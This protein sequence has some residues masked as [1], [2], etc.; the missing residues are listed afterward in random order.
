[1]SGQRDGMISVIRRPFLA[2]EDEGMK[3][4]ATLPLAIS[5][6][7]M[8]A[9]FLRVGELGLVV[10]SIA[11]PFVLLSRHPLAVRVIQMLLLA[12]GAEWIHTAYGLASGRAAAGMP[13][14]RML[15]ILGGVI[16]FTVSSIFP[17]ERLRRAGS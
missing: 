10:F 1:V 15:V 16:V 13:Y 9:H 12:A 3:W 7:L 14:A 5:A 11:V 17:L 6:L 4:L 8:S 2:R